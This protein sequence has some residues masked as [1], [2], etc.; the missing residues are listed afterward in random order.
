MTENLVPWLFKSSSTHQYSTN[1]S[2]DSIRDLKKQKQT[3]TKARRELYKLGK[4]IM[5]RFCELPQIPS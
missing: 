3:K 4:N 1:S 5:E 2:G